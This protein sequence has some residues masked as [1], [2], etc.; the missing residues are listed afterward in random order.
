MM[1]NARCNGTEQNTTTNTKQ[2][3][4]HKCRTVVIGDSERDI[5]GTAVS[6]GRERRDAEA[7]SAAGLQWATLLSRLGENTQVHAARLHIEPLSTAT[8]CVYSRCATRYS[9]PCKLR[10]AVCSSSSSSSSC[11]C[12]RCVTHTALQPACHMTA[13]TVAALL[14]L[15]PR[16][17]TTILSRCTY[18]TGRCC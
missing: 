6:V 10:N 2:I 7:A 3:E 8:Q 11:C 12:V 13:T 17:C 5:A 15:P 9:V 1:G 18:S 4:W 14:L 16:A